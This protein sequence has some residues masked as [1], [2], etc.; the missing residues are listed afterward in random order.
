MLSYRWET[1]LQGVLVSAKSG[2]LELG[3][4][5]MDIIGLSSKTVT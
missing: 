3:D 4:Y 2:R 5:F 1:T